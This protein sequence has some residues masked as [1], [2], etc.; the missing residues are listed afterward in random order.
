[1][2]GGRKPRTR[3]EPFRSYRAHRGLRNRHPLRRNEAFE[4]WTGLSFVLRMFRPGSVP[5]LR[6]I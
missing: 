2:T 4:D 6:F 3:V 5:L 1:M